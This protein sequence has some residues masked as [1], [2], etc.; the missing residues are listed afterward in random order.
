MAEIIDLEND[1]LFD[2]CETCNDPTK[3][4]AGKTFD[5]EGPGKVWVIY[6]CDNSRCKRKQNAIASYVIRKEL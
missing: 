6:T 1:P 2:D 3:R 4:V 5:V